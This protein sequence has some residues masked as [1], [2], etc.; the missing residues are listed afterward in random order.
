MSRSKSIL[1]FLILLASFFMIF[2]VN[3][4]VSVKAQEVQPTTVNV[5]VT[6]NLD[7]L[8]VDFFPVD[9]GSGMPGNSNPYPKENPPQ[10]FLNVTT[11]PNNNV[12]WNISINGTDMINEL[13]NIIPVNNISFNFT[14]GEP[15]GIE[16]DWPSFKNLSES[17]ITFL[18]DL[19]PRDYVKI[20]FYL[21]IPVGSANGTYNGTIWIHASSNQATPGYNN[22]TW[23]GFNNTTV[24]VLVT[25]GIEWGLKPIRF[26]TLSPGTNE[27]R[28]IDDYGWPTNVTVVDNTNILVDL[29]VNGTDLVGPGVIGSTNVIYSNYTN[30][31]YTITPDLIN[32]TSHTLNLDRPPNPVYGDFDN[33]GGVGNKTDVFSFWNITIPTVP[34][35]DYEGNV[36]ARIFPTGRDP[37]P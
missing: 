36:T 21:N 33:W 19:N 31:N 8:I 1:F 18:K 6:G 17:T 28:A 12:Q 3:D 9:F 26:G 5:T 35:G 34:G 30:N 22:Y 23:T 27:A 16:T 2:K 24:T 10:P 29:Y 14:R 20:F 32:S 25:F 15:G 4:F 11:G 7:K 37:T 13:G